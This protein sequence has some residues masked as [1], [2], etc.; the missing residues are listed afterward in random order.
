MQRILPVGGHHAT[1][2]YLDKNNTGIPPKWR[3][4]EPEAELLRCQRYYEKIPM[5]SIPA[6]T[7]DYGNTAWLKA[8]KRTTPSI[9]L[10]GGALNGATFAGISFDSTVG[11][12]QI[13]AA[14][15][16]SDLFFVINAR[17]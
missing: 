10:L 6:A 16:V 8:V 15:P 12:R 14:N 7:M 9:G 3:K 4:P 17:M 1:L 13:V 11:I 2:T 5:T